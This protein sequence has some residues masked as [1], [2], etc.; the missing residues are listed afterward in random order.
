MLHLKDQKLLIVSPHPDDEVLGCGGLIKRVKDAGGKVYVLFLTVG[1]TKEYSRNGVTKTDE[2]LAE[3]EKAANYL[4]YDDYRIAF[5]GDNFHLQL[6]QIPQKDIMAEIESGKSISL[7][8]IRPTIIACPQP[9]D[10][11]QDHRAAALA[12]FAAARPAPD[13][14]KP[15]QYIVLGYES[16]PTA[17]WW[18]A[19][20]NANFLVELSEKELH[21]KLTA[22]KLYKSQVRPVPHPRSIQAMQNLAR[23]R[24]M[25]AGAKAAEAFFIYRYIL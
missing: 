23:Y 11:N 12:V 24:G 4:Q 16:V 7:N 13:A 20:S 18:N 22:L 25:L 3:I 9:D 8:K 14:I 1:E 5:V 2:R 6:D 21:A 10:Y 17:G 19:S 15:L